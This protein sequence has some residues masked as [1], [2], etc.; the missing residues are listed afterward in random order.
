MH[1]NLHSDETCCRKLRTRTGFIIIILIDRQTWKEAM[2]RGKSDLVWFSFRRILRTSQVHPNYIFFFTTSS[3]LMFRTKLPWLVS[4]DFV[5][6]FWK[7]KRQIVIINKPSPIAYFGGSTSDLC[8][9][10]AFSE[11]KPKLGSPLYCY[12][13]TVA[14]L[15]QQLFSLLS[16]IL[17]A[18][19]HCQ[20][21]LT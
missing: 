3:V 16:S 2:K 6:Q 11:Y 20:M 9:N 5:Q 10:P 8:K 15:R 21:A 1:L 12:A 13:F 19:L 17:S 18:L 7:I 4:N 14:N